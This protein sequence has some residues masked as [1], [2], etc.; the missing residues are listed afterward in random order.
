MSLGQLLERGYNIHMRENSLSI[1]N[2]AQELISKVDM[3]KNWLF[4]LD[5][6]TGIQHC[7]KSAI[8]N[9]SWL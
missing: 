4:T 5:M 9:D 3:T 7:L 8:K 1:R 2:Q 6:Q